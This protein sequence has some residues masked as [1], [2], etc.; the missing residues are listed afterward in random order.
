[1]TNQVS[2]QSAGLTLTGYP[3]DG[4]VLLAFDLDQSMQQNLAGFAV[5]YTDPDGQTFPVLNR[6]SFAQA[7]TARPLRNSAC[8]PRPAKRRCRSSTG[9]TSRPMSSRAR[10][11]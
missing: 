11:R 8:G 3:G 7:I 4:A 1:M 5:T 10:L 2:Q 9:C 6:L